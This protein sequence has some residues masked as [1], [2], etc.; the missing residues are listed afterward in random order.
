LITQLARF[1]AWILAAAIIV[2]TLVPPT[3]RP[4]TVLRHDIEHAAIFAA[5]GVAKIAIG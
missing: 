1:A 4:V 5:A 3:M 2:L